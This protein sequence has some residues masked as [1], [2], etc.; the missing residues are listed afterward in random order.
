MAEEAAAYDDELRGIFSEI[1]KGILQ[2]E[3]LEGYA[4]STLVRYKYIYIFPH[5]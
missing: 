2:L 4:K 3:K 1:E 5:T